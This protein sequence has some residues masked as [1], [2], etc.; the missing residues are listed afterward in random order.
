MNKT[1][2]FIRHAQ[3]EA[4]VNKDYRADNFSVPL[5]QLSELGLKQAEGVVDYFNSTPDLIITSSYI[6]TKQTAKHLIEKY[7]NVPQEEW[8]IHEFTYLSLNR[9]FNTTFGERKPFVDEY[10]QRSDPLHQDGEGAESFMDF[11]NRTRNALETLKTRKEN[12]IVLFSHEYTIAAVKYLLEKN[13]GQITS[14]EMGE[15]RE[16]FLSNRVPNASKVEFVF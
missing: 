8:D 10:W 13:P 14:K 2:R 11:I 6:R 15:Y 5:V 4:N 1:I 9:C 3:S 7:P 16:Y 12:F